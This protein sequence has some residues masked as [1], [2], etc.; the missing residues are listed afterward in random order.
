MM[1]K[2]PLL[3]FLTGLIYLC[4]Q[5]L[6]R[7]STKPVA[8]PAPNQQTQKL[9][10]LKFFS[11]LFHFDT[12]F[13]LEQRP[14][15]LFER[16]K[17]AILNSS[18][19]FLTN[20]SG[21][22]LYRYHL[23]GTFDRVIAIKGEGPGEINR[24]EYATKIFGNQVAFW[25]LFRGQI[26][27]FNDKGNHQFSLNVD[28]PSLT[29]GA[30]LPRPAA[31]HW[32]T[33]E[34][35]VFSNLQIRDRPNIRSGKA[36]VVWNEEGKITRLDLKEPIGS[37]NL[38]H[39]NKYAPS[40]I[41]DLHKI[42]TK[43]WVGSPEFSSL[44]IYDFVTLTENIIP[45]RV[46]DP[47][48]QE[49]YDNLD[50]SDKKARRWLI[51]YHGYVQEIISLPELQ[52]VKVGMRGYVPFSNDGEQLLERRLI[53]GLSGFKDV[54]NGTILFITSKRNLRFLENKHSIVLIKDPSHASLDDDHP[55]GLLARL[56]PE[57]SGDPK[58]NL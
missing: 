17:C 41:Y 20:D 35:I 49:H 22:E 13:P 19:I 9:E 10:E 53:S 38:E 31:F 52:L 7:Q 15:I 33:A 48:T 51:N 47:L 56:K 25:D 45:I 54:H 34:E 8:S 43:Y 27:V 46:P 1:K 24:L 36:H 3:L 55:F 16:A 26:I 29:D 4:F 21:D 6:A 11:Q 37:R 42:G 23:D 50:L 40:S 39:E 57:Y 30:W 28:N 2:L 58:R 32:E 5:L 44:Q 12:T 14:E 18:S